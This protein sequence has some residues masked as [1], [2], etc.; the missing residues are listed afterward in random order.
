[1]ARSLAS[2][3]ALRVLLNLELVLNLTQKARSECS[4][5]H[6]GRGGRHAKRQETSRTK[7]VVQSGTKEEPE[8]LRDPHLEPAEQGLSKQA[9]WQLCPC[10]LSC[11]RDRPSLPVC[12]VLPHGP[13]TTVLRVEY[14]HFRVHTFHLLPASHQQRVFKQIT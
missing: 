14:T 6:P 11:W 5:G 9:F 8:A 7:R 13:K 10:F 1:M 4:R 2:I 12:D 3:P